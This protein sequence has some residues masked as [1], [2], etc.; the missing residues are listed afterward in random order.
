MSQQGPLLVV[1]NAGRPSFISALDEARMFP[2]LETRFAD[3]V[4]AVAQMQPSAVLAD[5]Q[6]ADHAQFEVLANSVAARSPYLPLVAIG[7]GAPLPDN[8]LPFSPH[9]GNFVR[10]PGRLSAALRVRALHITVLRRLSQ[11]PTTRL[12]DSDPAREATVLLI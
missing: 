11:E 1:S 7:P 2:V 10:L 6:G 12:P 9:A 3:A 8:A 4:R 5:M